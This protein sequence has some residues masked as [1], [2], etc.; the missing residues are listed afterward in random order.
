MGGSAESIGIII[1]DN[2]MYANGHFIRLIKS[3]RKL[4]VCN[5]LC[6]YGFDDKDGGILKWTICYI[7][8]YKAIG[9]EHTVQN[10]CAFDNLLP[11]STYASHEE[12]PS[13]YKVKLFKIKSKCNVKIRNLN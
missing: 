9:M 3:N 13:L 4:V 1:H 5:K 12:V 10:E 8:S 11:S 2:L 7:N 6:G